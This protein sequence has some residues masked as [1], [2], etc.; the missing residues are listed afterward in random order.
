MVGLRIALVTM[1]LWLPFAA[2]ADD[3]PVQ[4][5]AEP[6]PNA[7]LPGRC[8]EKCDSDLKAACADPNPI[9][10]RLCRRVAGNKHRACRTACRTGEADPM[11]RPPL[12]KPARQVYGHPGLGFSLSYPS[13][14]RLA[15]GADGD[16][17]RLAKWS[18]PDSGRFISARLHANPE[19]ASPTALIRDDGGHVRPT[20]IGAGIAAISRQSLFEAVLERQV[21]VSLPGRREI[22]EFALVIKDIENWMDRPLAAIEAEFHGER[23]VF[24]EMMR[25]FSFHARK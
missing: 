2:G 20:H 24:D 15:E 11:H 10:R 25:S 16:K 1:V 12:V 22:V 17:T 7:P 14:L 13:L 4:P 23:R 6:A 3:L 9:V 19:G 21:F 8:R 18:F 5:R